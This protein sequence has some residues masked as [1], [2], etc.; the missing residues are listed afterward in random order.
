MNL[1]KIRQKSDSL[2]EFK[3]KNLKT[4]SVMDGYGKMCR[5]IS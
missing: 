2:L 4:F 5:N 3:D 1:M